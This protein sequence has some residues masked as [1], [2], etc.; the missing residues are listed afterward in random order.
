MS[1]GIKFW[2]L[3]FISLP[4]RL[5]VFLPYLVILLFSKEKANEYSLKAFSKFHEWI[6]KW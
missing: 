6:F 3:F 2:I 5:L 4:I 1:L